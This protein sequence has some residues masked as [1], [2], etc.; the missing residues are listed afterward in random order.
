VP[1]I[2]DGKA[3]ISSLIPRRSGHQFVV[4]GD[5]SSGV[6]GALH[7]QTFA[8]IDA[9]VRRLDPP[10][11]LIVFPGDEIVGLT[12]DPDELR[13][14][15]R[16]WL[17]REMSWLDRAVTPLW[18]TT[19]NHT[20]YDALS[21]QVFAEMLSYLPR[22]GPARQ[23]GLSYWVRWRD[24]LLV[25][26]LTL[27]SGLG[28]EGHVETEWM[29]NVLSQNADARYKLVVGHYPMHPVN[30]FSGA[31]QREVGAEHAKPFWDVLV[32]EGV[33]AYLCSHILAYDAQVHRG[34]L[35]ICTA[36][37]HG[38][39]DAGGHRIPPLRPAGA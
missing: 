16:H 31:Y 15:W 20:T 30:G 3:S 37:G 5:S 13:K 1:P 8:A 38:T 7:E 27:G 28:G 4:Y 22:N 34:V 17:E 35:Q 9:V 11:E 25:F 18:H 21:E 24:L 23:E 2:E 19:G 39:S 12:A 32:A 26:V 36:G 29:Q 14:Q 10:P 33:L 6:P